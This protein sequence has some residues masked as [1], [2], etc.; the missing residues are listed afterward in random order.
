MRRVAL[1]ALLFLAFAPAA[2][3]GCGASATAVR[4]AAPLTVTFTATCDAASYTWSFGDGGQADGRTVTHAFAAGAWRPRLTTDAGAEPGPSVTA[5]S[6]VL[7]APRVA[8]YAAWVT[9]NAT[10]TPRVPVTLRGHA[11]VH[12]KLRVRVLG[13]APLVADALGVSSAPARILV[14][15]T[16]KIRLSGSPLVGSRVRVIAT[17]HPANAGTVAAPKVVDTRSAHVAHVRASSRPARG[18]VAASTEVAV[19][20]LAPQL[21][22]GSSGPSVVALEQRL[23]DLHYAIVRDGVFG[24]EDLEAVY[25]F[26]KVEGLA[27]TGIVTRDVWARL[28]HARTPRPRYGGSDHVEIDKTRQV[29]FLVRGGEVSLIVA[30]STGATGNTPLGIFHVYRKVSGYDWVL[31]YPSYFLRGFA[32]HGY[33]DVPPYP[34]SHGC[35]RIPMWIAQTVYA[36]IGYGSTVIVYT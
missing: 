8:H 10:V 9:V 20:V 7:S 28:L 35:A 3:A 17:L 31:Y 22:A 13:T 36:Q 18:W 12:G 16:L 4:G 23:A 30:T 5:I 34:A 1:V 2:H 26:Q 25:A 19:P 32:V 14:V 24:P 11:F 27:R 29:I 15:P 21:A 33:P 6:V